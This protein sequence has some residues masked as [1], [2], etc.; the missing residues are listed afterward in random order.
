MGITDQAASE[1]MRLTF[2]DGPAEGL[3]IDIARRPTG[4]PRFVFVA[5]DRGE[6]RS[7]DHLDDDGHPYLR[8]STSAE[9]GV[10]RLAR[11]PERRS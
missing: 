1:T 11:A 3:D 10:Y 6:A 5:V 2:E 4:P 9:G 8:K 7:T